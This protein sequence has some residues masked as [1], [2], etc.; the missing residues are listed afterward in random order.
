MARRVKNARKRIIALDDSSSES[1]EDNRAFNRGDEDEIPQEILNAAEEAE[2]NTL[3]SRSKTYYEKVYQGFVDW[4]KTK[5]ITI[6]NEVVLLAFFNEL[7]KEYAPSTLYNKH[8][9]LKTMIQRKEDVSIGDFHKLNKFL[10]ANKVGFEPTKAAALTTEEIKYFMTNAD[11]EEY[12]FE[13]A[14]V[15]AAVS[16]ALRRHELVDM[17]PAH[18]RDAGTHLVVQVP[19]TKTHIQRVFTINNPFRKIILK[20]AALRPARAPED[21]FFLNYSGGR[22]TRQAVGIN[23]MGGVPRRIATYLQS[24]DPQRY[25][26]HSF[27]HS[28]ATFLVDAGGSME[29]LKRHGGW[30]SDSSASGYLQ[31]S[32]AKKRKTN[33]MIMG[34]LL[35]EESNDS[36]A[37][38][39]MK[40]VTLN[41]SSV[42][43]RASG[44]NRPV[45]LHFHL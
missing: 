37:A 41:S 22:C 11:D 38:N 33:S 12:L 17:A 42:E 26:G 2:E 32:E 39:L 1:G 27:R 34:A 30:K 15:V 4:K 45:N 43:N 14:V 18:I 16:G 21:R 5:K 3:P 7:S 25:T 35:D 10:K 23:K 24:P 20:Y 44:S 28:S 13:K 19:K 31:H 8:S 36:T 40:G 29:D 9:I 6:S